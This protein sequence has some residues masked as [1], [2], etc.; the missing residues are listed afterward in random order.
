MQDYL[1]RTYGWQRLSVAVADAGMNHLLRDPGQ[2]DRSPNSFAY[3]FGAN[4]A[5][6][7]VR[8]TVE[9][10]AGALLREDTRFRPSGLTGIGPRLRYAALQAFRTSGDNQRFA[11]SR[12]IGTAGSSLVSSPVYGD[13]LT[14]PRFLE[15][16]GWGY[17]G[18]LQKSVL[19]E[20]GD[21]L[22]LFGDR[23]KRKFIR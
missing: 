18:H 23:V 11:Y 17:V 12:L 7:A 13:A 9:L 8:N 14:G 3:R 21:D 10:G 1:Q 5:R 20:F 16:L 22:K 19:T 6:R 4:M 2:W 15:D